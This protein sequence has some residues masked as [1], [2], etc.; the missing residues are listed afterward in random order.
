MHVATASVGL[1]SAVSAS[2]FVLFSC[3]AESDCQLFS[4]RATARGPNRFSDLYV[5][6]IYSKFVIKF[7]RHF[8]CSV[9]PDGAMLV[10]GD[11]KSFTE[12]YITNENGCKVRT[13]HVLQ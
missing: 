10:H 5:R 13:N 2:V 9:L 6:H 7:F 1:S 12:R 3:T 11:A 4:T 8:V